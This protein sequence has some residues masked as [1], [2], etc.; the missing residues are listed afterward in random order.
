MRTGVQGLESRL[1]STAFIR[2]LLFLHISRNWV[3]F[4]GF[5]EVFEGAVVETRSNL[6]DYFQGTSAARKTLRPN[7]DKREDT[8]ETFLKSSIRGDEFIGLHLEM[9]L[10]T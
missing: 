4:F 3:F 9:T 1:P 6:I 8:E 5:G 10:M 7:T 2:I